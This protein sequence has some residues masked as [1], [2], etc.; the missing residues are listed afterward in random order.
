MTT[1]MLT[2]EE[3]ALIRDRTFLRSKKKALAK[4]SSL[5][6]DSGKKLQKMV[7][8][9]YPIIEKSYAAMPPKVSRGENYHGLPYRVLD[10]PRFFE[11]ETTFS[12][13][14]V[15]LW[16]YY[17]NFSLYLGEEL[18][19]PEVLLKAKSD[20]AIYF[21]IAQTPWEHHFT[22]ENF[23]KLHAVREDELSSQ[24]DRGFIKIAIREEL[25]NLDLLPEHTAKNFRILT[26]A[27]GY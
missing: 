16:G 11:Q 7:R 13:R 24:L 14:V 19:K 10:F 8:E 20:N 5:L 12:Y 18:V 26:H 23:K 9:Q 21:C 3:R 2:D 6:T 1:A 27:A 22:V 17:I 25:Q 4:I 15:F